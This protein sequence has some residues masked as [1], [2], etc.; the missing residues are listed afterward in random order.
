MIR[1]ILERA[2]LLKKPPVP[3]PPKARRIAVHC[4]EGET[5]VHYAAFQSRKGDG[6]V[7]LHDK[8]DGNAVVATYAA[9][10]WKSITAG[11]RKMQRRKNTKRGAE[12]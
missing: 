7:V 2:G 11:P 4:I 5:F 10:S 9:G 6:S 1:S 8:Q 3:K 12:K